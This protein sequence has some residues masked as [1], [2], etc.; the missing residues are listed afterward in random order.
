MRTGPRAPRRIAFPQDA[1]SKRLLTI[2]AW[3]RT[4]GFF[5]TLGCL[6]PVFVG[7]PVL[8]TVARSLG[9]ISSLAF[10]TTAV[11]CTFPHMAVGDLFWVYMGLP[12][13][14]LV[15][16]G[17]ALLY[18]RS[19]GC[20]PFKVVR[21]DS[22][23]RLETR[24]RLVTRGRNFAQMLI[25]AFSV[26]GTGEAGVSAAGGRG[27]RGR[28]N[29]HNP[30]CANSWALLPRDRHHK[31]HGLQRPSQNTATQRSTRREERV[32]VQGPGTKQ[33]PD[34]PQGGRGGSGAPQNWGGVG[35][36]ARLTGP[37]ISY[38]EPLRR[39]RRKSF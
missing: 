15:I 26:C 37:L 25:I 19:V 8:Q 5:Q 24:K 9:G 31:E 6:Q 4:I 3:K 1:N 33:Q 23:E 10:P 22:K 17:V 7:M 39:R 29:Q 11:Q 20:N 13:I 38:Y 32:T 34:V 12:L 30:Q 21:L 16:G 28:T 27:C 2:S 14:G 35:K 36:R 18:D